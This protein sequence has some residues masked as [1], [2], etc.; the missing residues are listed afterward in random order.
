MRIELKE[1]DCVLCTV[2]KIEGTT[3][4]LKID[5]NGE[6]TM[7]TSEVAAGRIRN[8][9]DYVV[10]GKKIVC[11]ILKIEPSGNAYLS[12]R[13][14]T[15]KERQEVMDRYEKERNLLSVVRTI[16]KE[17]SGSI[18][19]KIKAKEPSV[20]EFFEK[21]KEDSKLLSEYFSDEE[22]EKILQIL[23]EKKEKEIEVKK[24]FRL[25]S[26]KS[27]GIERIKAILMPNKD[28]ITYLGASRYVIKL[29]EKDYKQA[30]SIVNAILQEIERKAKEEKMT[31]SFEK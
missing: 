21:A 28:K 15:G 12:L 11:K 20:L 5:N 29:K 18:W 8:L 22:A 31:F 9:R 23:K 4:F 30:N 16:S 6:G 3:V 19:E 14:V 2:N 24:D 13:R 25:S 26:D 17:K 7:I 27:D 1:K 10:P